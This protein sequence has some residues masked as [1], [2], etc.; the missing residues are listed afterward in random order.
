MTDHRKYVTVGYLSSCLPLKKVCKDQSTVVKYNLTIPLTHHTYSLN[1][2]LFF[3]L[4]SN[5]RNL[6]NKV[7]ENGVSKK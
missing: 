6:L 4:W 1:K 3:L 7:F 5:C 2:R